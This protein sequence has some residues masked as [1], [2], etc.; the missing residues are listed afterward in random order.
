MPKNVKGITVKDFLYKATTLP[1][2]KKLR[3]AV[4]IDDEEEGIKK[5]KAIMGEEGVAPSLATT[6]EARKIY[7]S[8]RI[9]VKKVP[10]PDPG[11]GVRY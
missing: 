4:M 6:D 10:I 7:E 5:V 2:G 9:F 11:S 1:L 8:G 3:D